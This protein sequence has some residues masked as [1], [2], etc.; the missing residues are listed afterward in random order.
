MLAGRAGLGRPVVEALA[1]A[2]ERWDGKGAPAGL[3]ERRSR[4]PSAWSSPRGRRPRDVAGPR[5]RD[6][7]E[8][9][10]GPRV[11]LA[12]VDALDRVDPASWP[13]S[14]AGTK[15][16]AARGRSRAATTIGPDELDPLLAACADFMDLK[17]PWSRGHRAGWR[18]SPRRRAAGPGSTEPTCDGLRRAGLLHDLGRV[19]VENGIWASR[20][21]SRRRNGSARALP[22]TRSGSW[23]AASRLRVPVQPAAAHHERLDG[24]GY[25]RSL[26]GAALSRPDRLLAAADVFARSSPTGHTGL[27][28]LRTTPL[29]CS[30]V[31]PGVGST[32]TRSPASSPPRAGRDLAAAAVARRAHRPRGG[33]AA[34]DRARPV[35]PRGAA[36]ASSSH[37]R[38]SGATSRTCTRSSASRRGRAAVF[39]MEHGLLDWKMGRL[40]D[41]RRCRRRILGAWRLSESTVHRCTTRNTVPDSRSSASTA[42][43]ARPSSGALPRP[44]LGSMDARS[45]TTAAASPQ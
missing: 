17:S 32:R 21:R 16:T 41:A 19:A 8:R 24:S 20:A 5:R 40:P 13:G 1:H 9:A 29:V 35:E 26:A 22:T 44:E 23:P 43:A 15:W 45:S 36:A 30:K 14:T 25:H 2:Y 42:P 38:R 11:R 10:P 34:P 39:A 37:R 28:T 18:R 27:P 6:L 4:S 12:V 3:A 7:A 31:R 33:G